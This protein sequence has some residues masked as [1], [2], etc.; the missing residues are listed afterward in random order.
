M[1]DVVMYKSKDGHVELTVNL[2]EE[3]VWLTQ[4]QLSDLFDKNVRTI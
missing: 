1:P 4:N 2:S 3:T